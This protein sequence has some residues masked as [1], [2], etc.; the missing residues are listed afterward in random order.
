[1]NRRCP[2]CLCVRDG[3]ECVRVPMGW[4]TGVCPCAWGDAPARMQHVFRCVGVYLTSTVTGR[5]CC[6][7]SFHTCVVCSSPRLSS[8]L[9]EHQSAFPNPLQ[10]N[11]WTRQSLSQLCPACPSLSV[12]PWLHESRQRQ[13][14]DELS[15][16]CQVPTW[17]RTW[18]CSSSSGSP[19]SSWSWRWGSGSAGA[20]SASGIT[21]VLAWGASAMPAAS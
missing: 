14:R 7:L 20:A 19:S 4:L 10:M 9:P 21:S 16:P 5:G 15:L 2:A 11:R 3:W 13:V 12:H 6:T 8:L 18:S 17:S 1:M